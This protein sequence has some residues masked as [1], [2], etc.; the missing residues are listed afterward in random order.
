M[1]GRWGQNYLYP[2]SGVGVGESKELTV[3]EKILI[4]V[5]A[6]GSLRGMCPKS[7]KTWRTCDLH[8]KKKRK[9]C[10]QNYLESTAAQNGT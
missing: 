5:Q 10:F 6:D 4:A 7:V 8:L 9:I 2:S 1:N 3:L